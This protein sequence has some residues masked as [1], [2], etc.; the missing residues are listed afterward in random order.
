MY[1][2]RH[3]RDRKISTRYYMNRLWKVTIK[4]V[5]WGRVCKY[6]HKRTAIGNDWQFVTGTATDYRNFISGTTSTGVTAVA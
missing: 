2:G 1:K 5:S 4:V 3:H 6:Y